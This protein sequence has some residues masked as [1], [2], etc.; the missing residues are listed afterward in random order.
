VH[1]NHHNSANGSTTTEHTHITHHKNSGT[2]NS[3]TW[4]EDTRVIVW[5]VRVCGG[6]SYKRNATNNKIVSSRP[7]AAERRRR[8]PFCFELVSVLIR[9]LPSV[10]FTPPVAVVVISPFCL[11]P[12][13]SSRPPAG[14]CSKDPFSAFSLLDSALYCPLDP[15]NFRAARGCCVRLKR[16]YDSVQTRFSKSPRLP[17]RQAGRPRSI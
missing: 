9:V 13:P 17:R 3:Y 12:A 10:A 14:G 8:D 1:C 15:G 6:K 5:R 7:L 16:S 2:G 4:G 11:H